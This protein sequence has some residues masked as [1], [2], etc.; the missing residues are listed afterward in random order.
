MIPAAA[1]FATA[2]DAFCEGI[3]FSPNQCA[4]VFAAAEAYGLKVKLHAEQLSALHGS[5]LAARHGAQSADHL[6]HASDGDVRVMAEAGNVA[7]LLLGAY[8][9]MRETKLPTIDEMRDRK[10]AGDRTR[11]VRLVGR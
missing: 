6:E 4:R 7:V 9:L 3:G 11:E 5:A 1:P 10:N 2:V 8:Y